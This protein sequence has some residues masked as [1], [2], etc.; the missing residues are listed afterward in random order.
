MTTQAYA[1]GVEESL[2]A[3]LDTVEAAARLVE[4]ERGQQ[5]GG[6][7]PDGDALDRARRILIGEI[8]L[9]EALAEIDAKIYQ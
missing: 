6:H 5:L 2:N 9:A 3:K 7:Q 1:R 8:T 4:I